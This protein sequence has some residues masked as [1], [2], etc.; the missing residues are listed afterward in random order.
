MSRGATLYDDIRAYIS[1]AAKASPDTLHE[2]AMGLDPNEVGAELGLGGQVRNSVTLLA[3][4][5]VCAALAKV[6]RHYGHVTT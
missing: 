5:R 2:A 1:V 4:R 3:L 6:E